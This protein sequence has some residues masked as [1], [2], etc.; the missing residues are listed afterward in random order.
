MFTQ[1][2]SCGVHTPF[3]K[4]ASC[5]K[6]DRTFSCLFRRRHHCRR[7]GESFCERCSSRRARLRLWG[8][9]KEKVRVCQRCHGLAMEENDLISK[10][11]PILMGSASFRKHG[12]IFVKAVRCVLHP[13]CRRLEYWSPPD[14]TERS[15]AVE[16]KGIDIDAMHS[17]EDS[18]GLY[19]KVFGADRGDSK[20]MYLEALDTRTKIEW[21]SALK[22]LSKYRSVVSSR[23][24]SKHVLDG[25]ITVSHRAESRDSQNFQR[26]N[27]FTNSLQDNARDNQLSRRGTTSP[28]QFSA[29]SASR[30]E[31]ESSKWEER[32]RAREERKRFIRSLRDKY[33][34]GRTSYGTLREVPG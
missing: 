27:K 13:S 21:T 4:D 25:Q 9:P 6:C 8:Y 3:A 5:S 32:W 29:E 11:I 30:V 17:V 1:S 20:T 15:L 24:F 16:V 19:L 22:T 26:A 23:G 33:H 28:R 7:C 18:G 10:W 31:A 12:T 14:I 2:M 34:Q